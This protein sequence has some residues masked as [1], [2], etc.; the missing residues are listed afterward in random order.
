MSYTFRESLMRNSQPWS[1]G[2]YFR[3]NPTAISREYKIPLSEV[4]SFPVFLISPQSLDLNTTELVSGLTHVYPLQYKD[5]KDLARKFFPLLRDDFWEKEH[6]LKIRD[7]ICP[8]N[9]PEVMA[10][11][12]MTPDS[13]YPESRISEDEIELRLDQIKSAG[14]NLVDIGGQSTR[15]GSNQISAVE[16][17]KRIS[18]AVEVA[19]NR[20]FTVSIDSFR[21]EVLRE[22]LEMGAH[23]IND[24]TGLENL[25]IGK[26]ANR[27]G[28]PLIVMHKKGDFRT[29]QVSPHYDNVIN[30]IIAFFLRKISLA[31]D[32]GIGDNIILDPGIGFGKRL[33]DNLT[34]INNLR[35]I[36]LGHPLLLGISRK[37][38]IGQVTSERVEERGISSLIFNTISILKGADIIRAHDVKE[39]LEMVKIIKKLKE[40]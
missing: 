13:F 26:L 27:Y 18:G 36:R 35:D 3:F 6:S 31:N 37:S 10:I 11:I 24:V 1:E 34:I 7:K 17:L 39:N 33:E 15:P 23:I 28:V 40:V 38:F 2:T 16:E 22:C 20:K 30:E 8:F 32:L 12:N 14:G 5:I 21:P 9:F 29:M 4:N 25:E 19:L